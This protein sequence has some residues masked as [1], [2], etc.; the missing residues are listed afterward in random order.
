[1]HKITLFPV[2]NADT[3]LIELANGKKILIDYA[4]MR[5][6]TKDDDRR[7]D[8][9]EE[10]KRL[11]GEE[12]TIDVVVFTHLDSDHIKGSPKFFN[13]LHADIY[14]S[15]ERFDIEEMW[16]PAAAIVEEGV[17]ADSRVIRQ[18]ARYRFKRGEGIKVFSTPGQL[19]DWAADQNVDLDNRNHLIINA[20]EII[21]DFSLYSDGLEIFVHSPFAYRTEDGTLIDRNKD[22]IAFNCKFHID[23]TEVLFN[24]FSDLGSEEI[25]DIVK[26][27]EFYDNSSRLNWDIFKTPH[28]CSHKSLANVSAEDFDEPDEIVA[29]LFEDYA[30]DSPLIISSS[31][32]IKSE[33]SDPPNHKAA[34][35]YRNVVS[36]KNGEFKVTM[37]HP[38]ETSPKPLVIKITGNGYEVEKKPITGVG[39]IV[40]QRSERAGLKK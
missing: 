32:P 12:K 9:P 30:N 38:T 4:D 15:Q 17:E 5:D 1:M 37:E 13:L 16:V 20:G 34:E 27:T 40:T 39:P 19:K 18:E 8:L 2:G 28:H 10:L 25:K 33:D 29:S 7:V 26:I 36:S 23:G 21:E 31:L 14:Q 6:A 24:S 35:F 11:M 22:A 3:S